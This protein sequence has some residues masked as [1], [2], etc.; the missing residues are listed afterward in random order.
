MEQGLG[1]VRAGIGLTGSFCTYDSVFGALEE[2][3]HESPELDLTFVLSY[4]AQTLCCRFCTPEDTCARIGRLSCRPPITDIAAA[5]PL[6]PK[7][8][9]DLFVIAPCTG[10]TL[11]KLACG[12]TD[13]TDFQIN[14]TRLK[15]LY[16]LGF[17]IQHVLLECKQNSWGFALPAVPPSHREGRAV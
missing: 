14:N 8:M 1:R 4:N 10:N 11:A 6:G 2:I 17:I 13:T 15:A 12:I 9:L 7:N 5:E 3:V 16:L